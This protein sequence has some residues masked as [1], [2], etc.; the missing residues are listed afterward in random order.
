MIP[1]AYWRADRPTYGAVDPWDVELRVAPAD[2]A[3]LRAMMADRRPWMLRLDGTLDW[4]APAAIPDLRWRRHEIFAGV[5][6]AE[7]QELHTGPDVLPAAPSSSG[8]RSR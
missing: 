7:A 8:S 5:L 2:R 6:R 3:A 4:G 1:I